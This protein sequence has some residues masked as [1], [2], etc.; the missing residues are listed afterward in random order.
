MF[1]QVLLCVL[2]ACGLLYLFVFDLEASLLTSHEYEM[3]RLML[4][5][6]IL[7]HSQ[8][9]LTAV[10]LCL[11]LC[12]QS[13]CTA[14]DS[15]RFWTSDLDRLP[16]A[17]NLSATTWRVAITT[18]WRFSTAPEEAGKRRAG[19]RRLMTVIAPPP[20][21]PSVTSRPSPTWASNSSCAT[22]RAS[23]KVQKYTFRPM[24]MV[25]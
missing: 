16:F 2:W 20:S 19:R 7:M 18:V 1:P 25:S 12:S 22:V 14:H 24:K 11:C 10:C 5:R 15:W 4:F 17:G 9:W 21:T 13:P 3:L 6:G 8:S 23:K